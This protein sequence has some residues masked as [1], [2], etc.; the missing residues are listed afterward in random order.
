[1]RLMLPE[2]IGSTTL[3]SSNVAASELS[4]WNSGTG[5][6]IGNQVKVSFEDNGT[7]PR[8]PIEIYESLGNTTGDYPPDSPSDWVFIS[9]TNRW[10]MF[11]GY[12]STQTE[13]STSIQVELDLAGLT[14]L[15][16]FN[17]YGVEVSLLHASTEVQ[18]VSLIR[19]S[20]KDWW[21]YFFAENRTGRDVMFYFPAQTPNSATLTI[22]YPDGTA[23]CGLVVIGKYY[24]VATT[25]Y[26]MQV[27][28]DDYSKYTTNEFGQTY[29]ATGNW[30]KRA[31]VRGY[32][33][34]IYLDRAY[35][36]IVDNMGTPIVVDYNEYS[37]NASDYHDSSDGLQS[38]LVYGFTEDFNLDLRYKD[39]S[40]VSH[41]VQGLI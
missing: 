31:D 23:K 39:H 41:E 9:A 5:Y 4:E 34:N 33:Q 17:S 1:M 7:T 8:R 36:L 35:N 16:V 37:Q 14:C 6:S 20:I 10:K 12:I 38:L 11:D 32:V 27:G 13:R 22:T 2:I 19:D 25:Q 24:D 18:T 40:L 29:L 21:D 26:G 3:V 15:G 30:A 28:I